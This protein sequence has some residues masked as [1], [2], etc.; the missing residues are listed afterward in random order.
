VFSRLWYGAT[1][2]A[3]EMLHLWR[4]LSTDACEPPLKRAILTNG[5]V[6]LRGQEDSWLEIDLHNEHLNLELKELLY[7]RRN[8]TFDVKTLFGYCVPSSRYI[9]ATAKSLEGSFSGYTNGRHTTRDAAADIRFL[10]DIFKDNSMVHKKGRSCQH[11]SLNMMSSGLDRLVSGG[12]K[13][14]NDPDDGGNR[15]VDDTVPVPQD[16][17]LFNLDVRCCSSQ[18][19]CYRGSIAKMLLSQTSMTSDKSC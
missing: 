4:L 8:G 5:S 9:T 18:T 19:I 15:D 13:N 6:N 10:A 12:L 11:R 14:F 7:A 2:Y 17:D 1:N 3:L 16:F